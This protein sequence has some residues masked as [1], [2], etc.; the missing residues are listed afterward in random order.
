M[1]MTKAQSAFRQ[2]FVTAAFFAQNKVQWPNVAFTPPAA[3]PWAAVH[4]MPTQPVVATLGLG[5]DD[6]VDGVF[7]VDLNYPPNSGTAEV[8]AKYEAIKDLFTAGTRFEY[9]G[10]EVVIRS[11]GRST[12]KMVNNFY[13]VHVTIAFYAYIVR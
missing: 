12:G 4:F 3:G 5:G 11:C 13:C 6:E 10:Q 9:Q 8:D 7:Q 1:S 2:A